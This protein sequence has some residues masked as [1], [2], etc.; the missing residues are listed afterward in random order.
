MKRLTVLA[1]AVL[2]CGAAWASGITVSDSPYLRDHPILLT[3]DSDKIPDGART[4]GPGW[5]VPTGL[6]PV[7][8]PGNDSLLVVAGPPGKYAVRYQVDW[9]LLEPITLYDKDGN[10][11]T[12]MQFVDWGEVDESI[13]IEIL[14]GDP[15]PDPDPN[16]VPPPGKRFVLSVAES[17]EAT[18]AQAMTLAGLRRYLE[19]SQ[20]EW[21][22][23]DPDLETNKQNPP[24]WFADYLR[25]A[26]EAKVSPPF[27]IV[28]SYLE[29]GGVRILC[30]K[31][32]PATAELAIELVK[33]YGG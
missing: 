24:E 33:K 32:L 2:L 12:V 30:I 11:I 29:S 9:I 6:N 7:K 19:S 10:P 13:A 26:A 27:I 31:P 25:R 3:S 4:K 8:I 15:D 17:G 5:I 21:R 28:G 20:H 23:E 1:Y 18:S 16:P 22:F 14:E